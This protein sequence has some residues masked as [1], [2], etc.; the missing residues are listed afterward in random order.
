MERETWIAKDTSNETV[1]NRKL[2]RLYC[3]LFSAAAS[4]KELAELC[5]VL[6]GEDTVLSGTPYA[7]VCP[8]RLIAFSLSRCPSIIVRPKNGRNSPTAGTD[9]RLS[10]N[11]RLTEC[12]GID[13]TCSVE[14]CGI[15]LRMLQKRSC[16]I[17]RWSEN[18]SRSLLMPVNNG[19]CENM[20]EC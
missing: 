1:A 13:R 16:L 18:R 15:L 6:A 4:S 3:R 20:N 11:C 10:Y 12:Y 2:S 8:F 17:S 14:R 7:Q 19:T 9:A 5:T